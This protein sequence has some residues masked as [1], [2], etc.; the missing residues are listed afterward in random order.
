MFRMQAFWVITLITILMVA[1]SA[2]FL[3][4]DIEENTTS[5]VTL[6]D[7]P[8]SSQA[9]EESDDATTLQFGINES[10]EG[11]DANNLQVLQVFMAHLSSGMFALFNVIFLIIFVTADQKN[12]YIKNI[13]GHIKRRY[14]LIVAKWVAAAVYVL[15]F[16]AI[17]LA[18][19]VVALVATQR[20]LHWGSA[21][22]YLPCIGIQ[23]LLQYAFLVACMTLTMVIRSRALGMTAGVCLSMGMASLLCMLIDVAGRRFLHIENLQLE[24]YLITT[25]INLIVPGV[26]GTQIRNAVILAV[27]YLAVMTVLSIINVEKRDLA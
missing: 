23:M 2:S 9:D 4:S 13:G 3:V 19:Q 22:T 12:G 21:Q 8:S 15:V 10:S 20:Y 17:M 16:D 26:A 6:V 7:G 27:C 14:R 5:E 1:V 18:T 25:K 11:M 24:N